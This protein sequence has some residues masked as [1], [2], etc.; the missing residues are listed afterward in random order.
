MADKS[1]I[2]W[3]ERTWNPVT[4]CTKVSEGCRHC[5]AERMSHRL[6]LM[7]VRKYRRA[8]N[9]STHEETLLEPLKWRKPRLVFVNSMSDLYHDTV[10]DYFI[11][12]V[13]DVM[14]RTPQH[15]YQVLTKRPER[16]VR[17]DPLVRWSA[18][19][20]LG[21]SVESERWLSRVDTLRKSSAVVKFLSIEPLLGPLPSLGLEG[22]DW[23]IVGGESGPGAR[24]M[25]PDW[26]REIRSKCVQNS[27]PFFF[28]QWG[29]VQKKRTGRVLD[30]RTWDQMP[31]YAPNTTKTGRW[32][33]H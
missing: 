13:F 32:A 23:V 4:G 14:N 12:S 6:Q 10:P 25:R 29:G 8:F 18:N 24:P 30:G 15:T 28:K 5:Y 33:S 22:I 9:V 20:W 3:T 19:V 17:L 21:T 16:A 26:V 31:S 7:G 11:A 1:L 2:E 27:V